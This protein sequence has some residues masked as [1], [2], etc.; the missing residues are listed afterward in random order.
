MWICAIFTLLRADHQLL[1]IMIKSFALSGY[2]LPFAG[3]LIQVVYFRSS[4][5]PLS[6][7]GW[8]TLY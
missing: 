3:C 2:F 6:V 7:D 1:E 8:Y 5:N 4:F